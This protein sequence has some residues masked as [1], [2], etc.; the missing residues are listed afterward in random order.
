MNTAQRTLA[1]DSH[2]RLSFAMDRAIAILHN[3]LS[4]RETFY[5]FPDGTAVTYN[6]KTLSWN[7]L[8]GLTVFDEGK[9]F[10]ME[11]TS[12]EEEAP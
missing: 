2:T 4:T 3:V 10:S 1:S 5:I 9:G 12:E 6:A 11:H 8:E 7:T